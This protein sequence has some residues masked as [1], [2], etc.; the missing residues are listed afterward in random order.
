MVRSTSALHLPQR[1]LLSLATSYE[2]VHSSILLHQS[3][4]VHSNIRLHLG[5]GFTLIH[6]YIKHD[7]S[8]PIR[9]TSDRLVHSWWC[10]TV[11]LRGSL[12]RLATSS[13]LVHLGS[14]LHQDVWFTSILCYIWGGG[15]LARPATSPLGVHLAILTLSAYLVH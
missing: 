3:L 15:S 9:A 10:D 13:H 2:V 1:L 11:V 8:L 4:L 12:I 7:G 14:V 5:L 6:C